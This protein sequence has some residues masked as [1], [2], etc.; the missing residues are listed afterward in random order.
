MTVDEAIEKLQE[1]SEQGR[2]NANIVVSEIGCVSGIA[3]IGTKDIYINNY[4]DLYH[5]IKKAVICFYRY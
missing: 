2:G 5:P 1:L 3:N 4:K